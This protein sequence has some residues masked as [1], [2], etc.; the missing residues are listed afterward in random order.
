MPRVFRTSLW[1]CI[2]ALGFLLGAVAVT[3]PRTAHA[4][5]APAVSD[6]TGSGGGTGGGTSYGDPDAPS[7]DSKR[8]GL[9]GAGVPVGSSTIAG[10][11]L[12]L[13]SAWMWRLRIVLQSLRGVWILP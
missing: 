1:T 2:L 11:D 6:D 7:G 12:D 3:Q 4:L 10:D 5:D 8:A 9:R 13:Q